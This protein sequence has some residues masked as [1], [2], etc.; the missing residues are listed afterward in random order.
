MHE[1]FETYG[2]KIIDTRTNTI[3]AVE[4]LCRT[5]DGVD[6]DLDEWFATVDRWKS[7]RWTDQQ[8]HEAVVFT[9]HTGVKACVN[10]DNEILDLLK[11][12]HIKALT[13]FRPIELEMTQVRKLASFDKIYAFKEELTR[14]N[15][16]KQISISLDDY[17]INNNK[18]ELE[19]FSEFFDTIKLD[20]SNLIG[21]ETVQVQN[22]LKDFLNY[23]EVY[24][25][26]HIVEGVE[27][28]Q[29]LEILQHLGFHTFQGFYFHKAEPLYQ[30]DATYEPKSF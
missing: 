24:N 12:S 15:Y 20:K 17:V 6:I 14:S 27:T 25:T 10:I 4:F 16:Q 7:L 8:I 22:E 11:V 21:L 13:G 3:S 18:H 19:R 2:Q 26:E 5:R 30:L 1:L 29:Q 23:L 9:R 28:Q